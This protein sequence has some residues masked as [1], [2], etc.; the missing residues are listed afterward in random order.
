MDNHY[1]SMINLKHTE[2]PFPSICQALGLLGV[3]F[4]IVIIV[5]V[6]SSF[7]SK[8]ITPGMNSLM[9]AIGYILSVGLLLLVGIY[10]RRGTGFLW[11]KVSWSLILLIIPLAFS[12]GILLEPII[13]AIPMPE[14]IRKSFEST[15]TSDIYSFFSI[16]IAAPILEELVFRGIILDGFLKRYSPIKSIMWSSIFFGVAHLNPWQF[17]PAFAIGSII[18]WLYWKSNSLIPGIVMH[19][20]N[21]LLGFSMFVYTGNSMT[22]VQ[23]MMGND[24]MY[25]CFY[26]I[27]L[28]VCLGLLMLMRKRLSPDFNIH[29]SS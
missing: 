5:V 13:D 10:K 19:F 27:C 21:N 16:V 15:M 14:L 6:V 17:I 2:T 23:R 3:F 11:K 8:F 12:V 4:L 29:P 20:V 18:G 26:G 1:K 25:Y 24:K 28:T 22:T 7:I 9:N